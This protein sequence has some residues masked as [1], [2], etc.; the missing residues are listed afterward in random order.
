M[1][2]AAPCLNAHWGEQCAMQRVCIDIVVTSSLV[3][4]HPPPISSSNLG[5][6]AIHPSVREFLDVATLTELC[7]KT[8]GRFKWLRVGNECGVAVGDGR[9]GGGQ[10]FTSE[11]LSE[12]LK[13]S[14]L[15]FAGSDV[16]FNLR[17]S[18]GVQVKS[19]CP[20]LPVGT[21]VGNGIVNSAELELS[22]I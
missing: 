7:R 2:I 21:L 3:M 8:C 16:V 6:E 22:C 11:Q 1:S 10:S 15:A 5:T 12:E 20:T 9:G 18:S 14:A 17:R 13:R 4:S 19:Y